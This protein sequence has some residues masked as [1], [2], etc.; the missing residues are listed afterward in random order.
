ML[1]EEERAAAAAQLAAFVSRAK[2]INLLSTGARVVDI[3]EPLYNVSGSTG[4]PHVDGKNWKSLLKFHG[5]SGNCFADTPP[6]PAG[7]SHPAFNVGGHMTLNADGSVPVGGISYLMPL[8]TWHNSTSNNHKP[9]H[10]AHTR[11]V[12]LQGY[13]QGEPAAMF[14]ARMDP[15]TEL[16]LVFVGGDGITFRNVPDQGGAVH[17]ALLV[18]R[19]QGPATD[20]PFVLL[21]RQG[22]PER[23][24]Y[25]VEDT[26]L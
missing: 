1:S 24:T 5:V 11:I 25:T 10:H 23:D 3:I 6:A 19:P 7:K 2:H 20:E 4:D 26:N 21:R 8:C 17:D 15:G 16:A 22:G 14:A 9:F 12:E 13:M 18:A